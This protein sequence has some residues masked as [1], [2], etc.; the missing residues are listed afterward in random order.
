MTNG[1]R[2]LETKR[3]MRLCQRRTVRLVIAFLALIV[4]GVP[5]HAEIILRAADAGQDE[6][7]FFF[8]QF[9]D[10]LRQAEARLKEDPGEAVVIEI[11]PGVHRI[12]RP[13]IL[14]ERATAYPDAPLVLRGAPDGSSRILGSVEV[15]AGEPTADDQAHVSRSPV[16]GNV[17]VID[18]A[19]IAGAGKPEISR[20]GAYVGVH[21]S[22]FE[23][24]QKGVR[25]APARW[26]ENGYDRRAKP[27]GAADTVVLPNEA[28][29]LLKG[30]PNLFLGGYWTASYAYETSPV[31]EMLPVEKAV[32]MAPLRREGPIQEGVAYF[33]FNAFSALSRPGEFVLDPVRR[34][35]FAIGFDGEKAFDVSVTGT[36]LQIQGARNI[37]IENLSFEES[38]GTAIRIKDADNVAIDRCTVRNSGAGGIN[39]EGG[40]GVTIS[41][42][43]IDSVAET[44]VY[45]S[46]GDRPSLTSGAHSIVDSVISDFGQ[47]SFTY[48]VGV[49]LA[50]VGQKIERCTF[51][52]GPHAAIIVQGNDHVIRGNDIGEVVEQGEDAGAIYMG[53]DWSER[54]T[55]IH[56]NFFHDIGG[57]APGGA[58]TVVG[59]NFVTAIYL[60]DQASGYRVDDNVFFRVDRPIAVHGGRDNVFSGNAFLHSGH[61]GILLY[62]R[63]EG[64]GGDLEGRLR[65]MPYQDEL[66]SARYPAL[67]NILDDDPGAP[68]HNSEKDNLVVGGKLKSIKEPLKASVWPDSGTSVEVE[69]KSPVSWASGDAQVDAAKILKQYPGRC[70]MY[71]G[72][73]C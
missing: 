60:D 73:R 26:P 39:V 15:R 33:A 29:E 56:G 50:G 55:V 1:S 34:R 65:R 45:L 5:T 59:R 72:F 53:R 68:L 18:L 38:R 22:G 8:R 11:P 48:R 21:E 17:V 10:L 54:G 63:G 46:G 13:I 67:R 40:K 28:F 20:R 16:A 69:A 14:D 42:C 23:F 66:W 47:S 3:W 12:Q 71:Q 32:R 4:S 7:D 9:N 35:A 31:Q 58:A 30:E 27:S 37:R 6:T 36:L 43:T 19:R 62:D 64:R 24:F 61:V 70:E 49:H 2:A 52:H 41:R 25:F 51:R 44:A 57:P